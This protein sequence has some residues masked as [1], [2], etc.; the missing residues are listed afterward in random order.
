MRATIAMLALSLV[1]PSAASAATLSE[2]VRGRILLDVEGHGEAWY[3]YPPSGERYYLGRPADAFAV[4]RG[5][6]LGITDADLA[7]IPEPNAIGEGDLALRRRLSGLILLQVQQ[8]GEA[9]YVFPPTLR[10][11]YLGRPDDAFAIMREL[12]LGISSADLAKVPVAAGSIALPAPSES[13]RSFTMALPRGSFALKVVTLDRA[14]Y[15]MITDTAEPFDC[16]TDCQARPLADSVGDYRAEIGIHGSYFCP[17]D[18]ADCAGKVNTFLPPVYNTVLDRMINEDTMRFYNRPMIA[19]GADGRLFYFHRAAKDFG[20]SAGEFQA[21]YGTP[22]QAAIGN[23]PSLVENGAVVVDS[24]PLE[25]GFLTKGTR[26]GIGWNG[27]SVFL[28]IA[29]S[30]TVP[31]L[32]YV[33]K[34]LGADF[35]MNL[36]GGGSAALY[37]GGQYRVGPG[38][39]LPTAIVFKKR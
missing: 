2:T 32:G 29:S 7:K 26:G 34:E 15:Q 4:M 18:Y 28:V 8:H 1:L 39:D 35:A 19:E 20:S 21:K 24:E 13:Y 14:S 6:G 22:L 12:G 31:D 30:A 5:L 10:R 23:W 33:M 36:D 11:R 27:K 25:S 9:W 3:V 38:R 17:P 37:E 16:E